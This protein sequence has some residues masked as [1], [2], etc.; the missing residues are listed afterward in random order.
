[1]SNLLDLAYNTEAPKMV[2]PEYGRNVQKMI[3]HAITLTD[4]EE[5]NKCAKA[6]VQVMK[7]INQHIKDQ[8]DDAVDVVF[9]FKGKP[10]VGAGL[11]S[12]LIYGIFDVVGF[13]CAGPAG[14]EKCQ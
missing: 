2:I 1:M 6:I 9:D 14:P 10:F 11:Q 3:D 7:Q 13:R 4:K 5:R 12:T 8:E